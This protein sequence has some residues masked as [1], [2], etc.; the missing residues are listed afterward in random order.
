MRLLN[1]HADKQRGS[2]LGHDGIPCFM[3]S[4][5]EAVGSQQALWIAGFKG[6]PSR[7]LIKLLTGYKVSQTVQGKIPIPFGME[8]LGEHSQVLFASA[9]K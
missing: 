2:Q 5:G 3:H 6:A 1:I 8:E 4:C 7:M 9:C